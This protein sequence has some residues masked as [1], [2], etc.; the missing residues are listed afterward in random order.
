MHRLDNTILAKCIILKEMLSRHPRRHPR[1]VAMTLL[2]SSLRPK[3]FQKSG[4]RREGEEY[5]PRNKGIPMTTGV[6]VWSLLA[7][8]TAAAAFI[9]GIAKRRTVRGYLRCAGEVSVR[10]FV[11][12]GWSA[13]KWWFGLSVFFGTFIYFVLMVLEWLS[14]SLGLRLNWGNRLLIAAC[15]WPGIF[16]L[17]HVIV[18]LKSIPDMVNGVHKRV[19]LRAELCR[20]LGVEATNLWLVDE[21]YL[22]SLRWRDLHLEIRLPHKDGL[23]RWWGAEVLDENKNVVGKSSIRGDRFE[24]LIKAWIDALSKTLPD[25]ANK[26]G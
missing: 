2:R 16:A 19:L 25:A 17:L 13:F 21:E 22:L 9:Y 24:K 1:R 20:L 8:L 10:D 14:R 12:L 7:V 6:G 26:T 15:L 4:L 11:G 23:A 5:N 18:F 3:N